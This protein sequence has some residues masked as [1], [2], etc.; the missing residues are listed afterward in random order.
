M[1]IYIDPLRCRLLATQEEH[2]LIL[3]L[4]FRR[5]QAAAAADADAIDSDMLKM[6]C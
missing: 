4:R 5:Q 2:T 3:C 1:L 6:P